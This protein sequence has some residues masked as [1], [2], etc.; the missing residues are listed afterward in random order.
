MSLPKYDHWLSAARNL[1]AGARLLGAVQ[2]LTQAPQ[3]AY[4]ELGLQVTPQGF[5]TGKLPEGGR[6][7][8][9]L[10]HSTL[11]YS[12][13]AGEGT[14]IPLEDRPLGEVFTT[15]FGML[16]ESELKG[17]LPPGSDLFARVAQGIAARGDRYRA[18]ERAMLV[19]EAPLQIDPRAARE[20]LAA[21]QEMYTGIARFLAH[22]SGLRTPLV[23]WPEGFDLSTMI[24][25]GSEVDEGRAH[26]NFGFAPYSE[27]MAYPYLY[28]YAY[29]LPEGAQP[30]DLPAGVHWNTQGWKGALLPYERIADQAHPAAYVEA[31]C[32]EIERSLRVLI[33]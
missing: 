15:L 32:L 26:L 8:L 28:A 14:T 13:A 7:T 23:V 20:Y 11:V 4:L 31:S 6:V 19:E 3:P 12:P 18:A 33:E 25:R 10:T 22:M 21:V 24:F 1:H 30:E 29:P 2:R 27:G 9:D 5:T 17:V 16:A